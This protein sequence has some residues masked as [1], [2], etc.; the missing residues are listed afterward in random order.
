[1]KERSQCIE[2][3]FEPSEW[4]KMARN[5]HCLANID[6]QQD[7]FVLVNKRNMSDSSVVMTT[8]W[9]LTFPSFDGYLL[10]RTQHRC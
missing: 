5:R 2:K 10:P 9:K 4:S 8:S 1:M 6:V 3:C 7:V